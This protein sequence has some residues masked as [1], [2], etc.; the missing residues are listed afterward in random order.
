MRKFSVS[1]GRCESYWGSVTIV[2]KCDSPKK[3][4]GGRLRER[5]D[6]DGGYG[7]MGRC[8]SCQEM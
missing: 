1:Y 6:D 3:G 5:C 4:V 8:C 2:K 7:V